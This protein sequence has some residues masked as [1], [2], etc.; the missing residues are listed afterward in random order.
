M[1]VLRDLA[2]A[3]AASPSRNIA[4]AEHLSHKNGPGS[5]AVSDVRVS[6]AYR[7]SAG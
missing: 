5:I 4:V 7:R 1:D 3:I 6:K 2:R